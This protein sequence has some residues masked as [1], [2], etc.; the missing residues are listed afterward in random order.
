MAAEQA[1]VLEHDGLVVLRTRRVDRR[2]I[3]RASRENC[4]LRTIFSRFC[5]AAA[6]NR[7][8]PDT[9]W[10]DPTVDVGPKTAEV[11]PG[12]DARVPDSWLAVLDA[13][14]D[15]CAS[16]RTDSAPTDLVSRRVR[17]A[18]GSGTART[19]LRLLRRRGYVRASPQSGDGRPVRWALTPAGQSL[20]RRRG[21]VYLTPTRRAD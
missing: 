4:W 21:D 20:R 16:E 14:A 13:L 2:H 15:A 7:V 1:G 10:S 12:P 6:P 17:Y 18:N 9:V 19:M 3:D 8:R 11:G 5:F